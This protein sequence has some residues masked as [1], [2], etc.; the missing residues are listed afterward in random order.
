VSAKERALASQERL[1]QIKADLATSWSVPQLLAE[2]AREIAETMEF[3]VCGDVADVQPAVVA[4]T[5]A[6]LLDDPT[7]TRVVFTAGPG[8]VVQA[9]QRRQEEQAREAARVASVRA[10]PAA[11]VMVAPASGVDLARERL[12][13]IRRGLVAAV[14][15]MTLVRDQ[16]AELVKLL[17]ASFYTSPQGSPGAWAH[18]TLLRTSDELGTSVQPQRLRD[19]LREVI[20][21]VEGAMYGRL[22]SGEPRVEPGRQPVDATKVKVEFIG[23]IGASRS[24]AEVH[25]V[26]RD[27]DARSHDT[28]AGAGGD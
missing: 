13:N 2:R 20:D 3:I 6:S 22:S 16:L 1:A 15:S 12:G 19:R 10:L 5:P 17:D 18:A 21:A 7:R 8:A 28:R 14:G 4:G 24:T 23:A 25:L 27:V 11:P 9:E 26:D